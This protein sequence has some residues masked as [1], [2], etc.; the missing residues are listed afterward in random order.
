MS[1]SAPSRTVPDL[2][3]LLTHAGHVLATQMA[4]AM[5]EIGLTPRVYCVL[6][7]A[8]GA[9]RRAVA[10]GTKV[11]DRVRRGVLDAVGPGSSEALVSALQ[12]LVDGY[13]AVPAGSGPQVRRG[14]G[15]G[16]AAAAPARL[17]S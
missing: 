14:G 3:Y 12:Q 2:S 1:T 9:G 16:G 5:A 4:A 11:A 17:S 15:A 10:E 8:L 7:H 6:L 13:L